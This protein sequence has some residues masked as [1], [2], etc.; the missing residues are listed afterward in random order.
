MQKDKKSEVN[1]TNNFYAPIGQHID[2]VDTINLRMD[3]DGTFHY[4]VVES[5]APDMNSEDNDDD[6][7]DEPKRV[8]RAID[9]LQQE[10]VLK[11]LYDYTWVMEAMNQTKGM[12][13]FS[14]PQSFI[15]YLEAI[16]IERRPSTDT[17]ST[18]LNKMTGKFPNWQFADCDSTEALRRI[19]VGKR[20]VSAY[21]KE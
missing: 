4:G 20:F 15:D 18:K 6:A 8:R 9:T 21:R 16:G 14:T 7:P 10:K 17:I 1:I 12:P 2:H 19:N 11:N 13:S 3:G 5:I